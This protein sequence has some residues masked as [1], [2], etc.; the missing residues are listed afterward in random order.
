[1]FL[2]R[3]TSIISECLEFSWYENRFYQ[4]RRHLLR[5]FGVFLLSFKF[6]LLYIILLLLYYYYCFIYL[7]CWWT[8]WDFNED[9]QTKDKSKGKRWL[10][11]LLPLQSSDPDG[12]QQRNW[13]MHILKPI[14]YIWHRPGD[15]DVQSATNPLDR[16]VFQT[17]MH[18]CAAVSTGSHSRLTIKMC[19]SGE[20]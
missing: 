13:E 12:W 17:L 14:R 10:S 1:M 15:G 18:Y 5:D 8:A 3:F 4:R 2:W 19:L 20:G 11:F 6:N 16:D 7:T 9:N